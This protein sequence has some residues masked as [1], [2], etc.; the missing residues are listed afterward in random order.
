MNLIEHIKSENAGDRFFHEVFVQEIYKPSRKIDNIHTVLD[1]GA[2]HGEYSFYMYDIADKIYAIEPEEEAYKI[3]EK[4]CMDL[5]KIRTSNVAISDIN[6]DKWVEGG[7]VGGHKTN[8]NGTGQKVQSMT[9]AT[10]MKENNIDLVD[11]LKIDIEGHEPCVFR[12]EDF[13]QVADKIRFI[14]GEH[15]EGLK[16]ILEP[17]GFKYSE[18]QFG[19]ILQK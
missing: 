1:I 19:F 14:I 18:Y 11:V 3:L 9:L 17:Y 13:H 4:N 15:G 6:G 5:H 12:A 16:E 7:V 8:S 10:Y 2:L